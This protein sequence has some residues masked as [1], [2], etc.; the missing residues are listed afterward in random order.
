MAESRDWAVCMAPVIRQETHSPFQGV[1][2]HKYP[3]GCISASFEI[4]QAA[5][6]P[7]PGSAGAVC[8]HCAKRQAGGQMPPV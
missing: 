1:T 4:T 5:T 3:P 7:R 2:A 8:A 6:Y